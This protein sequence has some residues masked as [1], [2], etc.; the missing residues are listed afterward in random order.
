VPLPLAIEEQ[1]FALIRNKALEL[2]QG[3]SMPRLHVNV[4]NESFVA[5]VKLLDDWYLLDNNAVPSAY[6]LQPMQPKLEAIM[7]RCVK[8][9][10]LVAALNFKAEGN[11]F[12]HAWSCLCSPLRV[13]LPCERRPS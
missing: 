12:L 8:A 13:Q 2:G 1:E 4:I 10:H 9:G 6:V 3:A 11:P 5:D 7:P